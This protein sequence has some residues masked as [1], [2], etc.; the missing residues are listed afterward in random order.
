MLTEELKQKA[1]E[2][3]F[4]ASLRVSS[5]HS[6]CVPEDELERMSIDRL[7][8]LFA[9]R[10]TKTAVVKKKKDSDKGEITFTACVHIL[11]TDELSALL[12]E[13]FAQGIVEARKVHQN[14]SVTQAAQRV[15]DAIKKKETVEE[16]D[17][18]RGKHP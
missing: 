3:L 4:E 13:A 11:S 9:E 5:I 16:Y 6:L 8:H 7:A 14:I 2:T 12:K 10:I 1:L 18:F 15:I 17:V